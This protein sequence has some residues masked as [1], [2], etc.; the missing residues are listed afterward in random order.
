MLLLC[1]RWQKGAFL[2]DPWVSVKPLYALIP[3]LYGLVTSNEGTMAEVGVFQDKK[4]SW[5]LQYKRRFFEWEKEVHSVLEARL[6]KV[7]PK[8]E[9]INCCGLVILMACLL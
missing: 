6:A 1:G 7:V 5:N 4:L 3:R 8:K 9:G 2:K